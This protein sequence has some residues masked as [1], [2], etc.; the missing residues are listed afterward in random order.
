MAEDK[1]FELMTKM[2]S[3]F[4]KKFETIENGQ[5]ELKEDVRGLK[6]DVL[7]METKLYEDS[8]ALYD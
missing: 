6:K 8:K 4:S 3:E 7:R 2:Y 1:T 5:D